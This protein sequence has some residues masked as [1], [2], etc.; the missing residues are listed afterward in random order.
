M[1]GGH[2]V[3]KPV[4]FLVVHANFH[5]QY[6]IFCALLP[7]VIALV[8]R[9]RGIRLVAATVWSVV[10]VHAVTALGLLVKLLASW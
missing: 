4:G 10:A 6:A 8:L 1:Q 2:E 3:T 9:R 5:A 7:P